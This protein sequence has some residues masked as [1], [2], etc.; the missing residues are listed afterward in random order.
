V[1]AKQIGN[2][3]NVFSWMTFA[4]DIGGAGNGSNNITSLWTWP[5]TQSSS[6]RALSSSMT[7]IKQRSSTPNRMSV[8]NGSL[9]VIFLFVSISFLMFWKTDQNIQTY[10][11]DVNVDGVAEKKNQSQNN[12]SNLKLAVL[13]AGSTQ[14]FLFDSFVE[15]VIKPNSNSNSNNNNSNSGSNNNKGVTI[16]Y[17]A[18]L[19]LKSGPAFRQDDGYMGHLAGYDKMFKNILSSSEKGSTQQSVDS[20]QKSM[21]DTMT[22]AITDATTKGTGTGTG[23]GTD[24]TTNLRTL[25]LLKEPIENDI[26]LDNV[27][28]REMNKWNNNYNNNNN[29]DKD[30]GEYDNNFDLYSQFPMMD[31]RS[32]ALVRT[33]AGNKNMIRLFLALE[34]LYTNEFIQYE[35]QS[36]QK[37]D[38]VLILRDDTLFLQNF[39]LQDVINSDPNADA[40]ILSCNDRQ[41][42]ML[43]PEINDHGIL[44]KRSKSDIVGKYITSMSTIDLNICHKSV[45][46]FLGKDR[47]CNSEM[48]LKYILEKENNLNVKLVSQSLLPFQRSVLIKSNTNDNTNNDNNNDEKDEDEDNDYYC[49]HK[50]CQSIDNPLQ[51][52]NNIKKCK[53]LTTF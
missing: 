36:Q 10:L 2:I 27:N 43:I 31:H 18:I 7:T 16:D 28:I 4:V 6:T 8:R 33:K 46:P 30:K 35:K 15:H 38:Y 3:T 42:Q 14:R 48:I 1:Q 5:W 12:N 41:P 49:Y 39:N 26:I 37:Y 23:T 53:E 47:G 11:I 20:I 34:S 45:E 22:K 50:F 19:T 13:V 44:I 40:Y 51:L 25:R 29:K 17:F 9:F 32:N 21:Y 52:P 24:G